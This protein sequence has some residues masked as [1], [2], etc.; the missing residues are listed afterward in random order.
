MVAGV[1][2][3]ACFCAICFQEDVHKDMFQENVHKDIS[4]FL[5]NQHHSCATFKCCNDYIS[6]KI[7]GSFYV[8]ISSDGV[9][10]VP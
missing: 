9:A 3:N 6:K 1:C 10:L 8:S 4:M 7:M 2:H 5:V